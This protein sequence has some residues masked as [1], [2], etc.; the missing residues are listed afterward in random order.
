[1]KAKIISEPS[2]VLEL[3]HEEASLLL[4]MC[5][6]SVTIPKCLE[7]CIPAYSLTFIGNVTRLMTDVSEALTAIGIRAVPVK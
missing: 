7:G 2:Y 4:A 6:Q 5:N 1:M 3:N